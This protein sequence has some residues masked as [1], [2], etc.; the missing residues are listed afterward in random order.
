MN[1]PSA[2]SKL[3]GVSS[4]KVLSYNFGRSTKEN[5]KGCI[6]LGVSWNLMITNLKGG[7]SHLVLAYASSCEGGL[8]SNQKSTG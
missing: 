4:Y 6:E 7:F 3:H 1:V 5:N 2:V 8:K